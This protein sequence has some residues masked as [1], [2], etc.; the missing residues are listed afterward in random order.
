M[1]GLLA[2]SQSAAATAAGHYFHWGVVQI[3][4][5]NLLIV[6]VMIAVFLLALLLPFPRPRDEEHRSAVRDD[7]R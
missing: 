5:A 6:L 2:H 7:H 3:S 1:S 4:L